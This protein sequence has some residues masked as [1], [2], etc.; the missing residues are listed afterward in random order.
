MAWGYFNIHYN[1]YPK[2]IHDSC[3]SIFSMIKCYC[4]DV[5]ICCAHG[6]REAKNTKNDMSVAFLRLAL[7][8]FM[9]TV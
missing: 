5:S 6:M 8:T 4:S 1:K 2:N 3:F 9:Q 7:F